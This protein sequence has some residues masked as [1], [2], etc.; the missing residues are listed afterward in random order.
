[1]FPRVLIVEGKGERFVL[2]ELLE[3]A[4]I[5]WPKGNEPVRIED[6]DGIAN[7][8]AP[9]FL[10]ATFKASGVTAVGIV[11]DANGDPAARWAQLR[12]RL[13]ESVL[14]LPDALPPAGLVHEVAGKP[15]VGVWLMPDNVR[16]GMLETLLLALRTGYPALHDHAQAATAQARSLGAPFRDAHREKAELHAWLAWQD[17][18]GRQ[19]HDAVRANVL[20]PAPLV[21][22]GFVA[23]F[24]ALFA[25]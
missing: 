18:P 5:A 6:Q 8:L 20:P 15:R 21:T 23:W 11:V 9:A 4:G 17:P 10:T 1:M 12:A 24:R 3:L 19:L 13:A 7:I 2:P 14:G 25:L 16:A 22:D